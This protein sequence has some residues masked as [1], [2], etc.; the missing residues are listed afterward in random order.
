M[1]GVK[2]KDPS[3]TSHYWRFIIRGPLLPAS[4]AGRRSGEVSFDRVMLADASLTIMRYDVG[5]CKIRCSIK[6]IVWVNK[7]TERQ[8]L[9]YVMAAANCIECKLT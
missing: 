4:S 3:K 1:D 2:D 6:G 9:F 5:G 8:D 7:S